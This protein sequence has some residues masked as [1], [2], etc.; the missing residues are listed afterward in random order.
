MTDYYSG[1]SCCSHLV[2]IAKEIKIMDSGVIVV[3]E[4]YECQD[5]GEEHWERVIH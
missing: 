5:C 3:K 2:L 4:Y 1:C